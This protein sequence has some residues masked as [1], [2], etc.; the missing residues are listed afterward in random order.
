[1]QGQ[2]GQQAAGG[3][4]HASYKRQLEEAVRQKRLER[5]FP[6]GSANIDQVASAAER[7]IPR[8]CQ[9]WRLQPEIGRDL[10]R[11]G[12]YDI[13]IFVGMI[14]QYHGVGMMRL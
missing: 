11:L 12:L 3:A 1:M 14:S 4:D 7:C 6:P 2:Y 8:I 10:A 13:V 9:E 5:F